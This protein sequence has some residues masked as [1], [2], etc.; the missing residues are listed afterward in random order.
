M[1][2]MLEIWVKKTLIAKKKKFWE[3]MQDT[4]LCAQGWNSSGIFTPF[5][6]SS[7]K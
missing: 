7:Y 4:S 6:N 5:V 2:S 1:S 3:K